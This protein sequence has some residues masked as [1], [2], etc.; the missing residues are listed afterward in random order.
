MPARSL[1]L[2]L[3]YHPPF[4]WDELLA[5]LGK[6]AVRGVEEVNGQAY[7]RSIS[8]GRAAGIVEIRPES[9][10]ANA[11]RVSFAGIGPALL[12]Q[13]VRRVRRMLDLDADPLAIA[14]HLKRDKRLRPLVTD[15]PGM[16]L[17]LTWDPFEA[18]VRAVLGQQ[19]SVAGA[20][21]IAG[22]LAERYGRPL[23]GGGTITRVFPG[24][25]ELAGTDI[26]SLG[27]PA[28]RARTLVAASRA[29]LNGKLRFD[30]T[31]KPEEL[32]NDLLGIPGIGPW[33]AHYIF[34]RGLGEPDAFP[35][36]D[37]GI[38]K[39]LD[40]LGYPSQR[41]QRREAIALLSPWRG[42]AAIYFWKAMTAGG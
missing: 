5:F 4:R 34:L 19:I 17:P 35:E 7:R 24:P 8:I 6:R 12:G 33:S 28:S 14:A 39:A 23:G 36:S 3:A 32:E 41:A 29:I 26:S 1:T 40:A 9:G 31:P 38:R 42:Y 22:R 30:G 21:T 13:A 25:A 27:V 15:A 10:G 18:V 37:L 16:R 11:V 2:S 20:I